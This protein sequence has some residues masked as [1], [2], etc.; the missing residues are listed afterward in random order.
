MLR[1]YRIILS[2][3]FMCLFLLIGISLFWGGELSRIF[4]IAVGI[5]VMMCAFLAVSMGLMVLWSLLSAVF[6]GWL[7]KR[8]LTES[9]ALFDK[10]VDLFFTKER[11][12]PGL[13]GMCVCFMIGIIVAIGKSLIP[14][15]HSYDLDPI[16]A[17]L[18]RVIHGGTYPD[19]ILVPWVQEFK[20]Y[21]FFNLIYLLWFY[22]IFVVQL[23]ALFYDNDPERR[24]RF[25][26]ST[27][28]LWVVLGLIFATALSSVGPIY[29]ASF[30]PHLEN[31]Y[32]E[33]LQIL[34]SVHSTTE[35][36]VIKV[37]DVLVEYYR[38]DNVVNL[39]GISAMPS[40]H[41]AIMALVTCYASAWSYRLGLLSGVYTL[42]IMMGSVVLG[43]HYAIDG[44]VAVI[45]TVAVWF[46]IGL[47]L[48]KRRA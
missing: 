26:W 14:Y 45:V 25:L 30:Y 15:I 8:P 17:E 5:F 18:D 10:R 48:K 36:N 11:I 13:L 22:I 9:M 21:G 16:F 20:L 38:N 43:W 44:Y 34:K 3:S 39:N 4:Y 28:V 6:K 40:M 19:R 37:S 2:V 42:L 33:F 41:V 32:A 27:L 47:M 46:L 1:E 35:L 31:P 7:G 29:Y 24:M 23:C 12:L